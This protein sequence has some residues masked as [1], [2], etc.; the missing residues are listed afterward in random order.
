MPVKSNRIAP[1]GGK[2]TADLVLI[3]APWCG[4]SK[5]MLP[6]YDRVISDYHGKVING[7]TL[8]ILKYNSDVDKGE[9]EKRNVK[10][11]P[12]LFFEMN[13]ES[14]KF[15]KRKYDDI[16]GELNNLLK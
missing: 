6:D 15:T 11:F 3:Y 2:G 14:K 13:G 1:S 8:N 4:H 7:Y 10:G 12:S 5:N 16:I 9:V